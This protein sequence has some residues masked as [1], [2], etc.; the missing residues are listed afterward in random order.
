M[1]SAL[2]SAGIGSTEGAGL[3]RHGTSDDLYTPISR[4]NVTLDG[5]SIAATKL[6]TSNLD[7]VVDNWLNIVVMMSWGL[8]LL[9]KTMK[10]RFDVPAPR[11]FCTPTLRPR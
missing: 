6:W 2:Q 7:D 3:V 4:L 9:T 8:A 1:G 10:H 5:L 11:S